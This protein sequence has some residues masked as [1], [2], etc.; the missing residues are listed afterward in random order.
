MVGFARKGGLSDGGWRGSLDDLECPVV[1][2][3]QSLLQLVPGIAVNPDD[4]AQSETEA[5]DRGESIGS[6]AAA[7][8]CRRMDLSPDEVAH[9]IDDDVALGPFGFLVCVPR[10]RLW[11]VQGQAPPR[12]PPLSV[13]FTFWLSMTLTEGLAS[14]PTAARIAIIRRWV[15]DCQSPRS[16]TR[17]N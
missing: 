10:V 5:A 15:I 17:R 6:A 3:L 13:I 9:G 2:T 8:D 14:R 1:V 16:R 7:L 4:A 12:L 11:P